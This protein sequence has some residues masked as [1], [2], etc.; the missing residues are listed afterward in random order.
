MFGLFKI[1]NQTLKRDVVL[2]CYNLSHKNFDWKM[3]HKICCKIVFVFLYVTGWT[4]VGL[5]SIH[6]Y[7]TSVKRKE[8]CAILINCNINRFGQV[9]SQC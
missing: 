7:C 6:A 4:R 1:R 9:L 3:L 8:A 5:R 2:E